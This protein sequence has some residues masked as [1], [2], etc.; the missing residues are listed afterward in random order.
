MSDMTNTPGITSQNT[1]AANPSELMELKATCVALESQTHT[2]RVVLL[3][4]VG[5]LC[6]FFWREASFNGAVADSM[7]PQMAEVNQVKALLEKQD[8]SVEKQLQGLQGIA[9]RLKEYGYAHPDYAQAVLAKYGI[10]VAAAAPAPA[11][12]PAAKPAAPAPA[13]K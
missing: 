2:L 9:Q 5:A 11:A 10:V 7:L 8:S 3:I 6:C 4:V 13:K 1:P 12:L